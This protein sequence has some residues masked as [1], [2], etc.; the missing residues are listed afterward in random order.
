MEEGNSTVFILDTYNKYMNK[1]KVRRI[2]Q[3]HNIW[4]AIYETQLEWGKPDLGY[5][6]DEYLH[7]HLFNT[8]EEANTAVDKMLS[9]AK[10]PF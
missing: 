2:F 7:F 6:D 4:F 5:I 8:F 3:I 10:I 1:D 9:A